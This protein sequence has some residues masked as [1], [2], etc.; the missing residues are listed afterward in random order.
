[1]TT[2]RNT[3]KKPVTENKVSVNKTPKPTIKSLQEQVDFLTEQLTLAN[4]KNL[5]LIKENETLNK[6]LKWYLT[7]TREFNDKL[8][9]KDAEVKSYNDSWKDILDKYE[10]LRDKSTWQFFKFKM[11]WE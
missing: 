6:E 9:V 3:N 1:M 5:E 11:G 8:N 7:A 10:T 4:G 2:K